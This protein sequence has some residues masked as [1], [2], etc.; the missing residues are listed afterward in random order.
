MVVVIVYPILSL[1]QCTP[2]IVHHSS[3]F[4]WG[5][6]TINEVCSHADRATKE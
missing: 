2:Q 5:C 4:L 1:N 3:A 6:G